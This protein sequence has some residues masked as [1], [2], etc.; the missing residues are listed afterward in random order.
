MHRAASEVTFR[1]V[2]GPRTKESL[3]NTLPDVMTTETRVAAFLLANVGLP[4]C[5]PCMAVELRQ[6]E[7][8]VVNAAAT[9]AGSDRF[10]ITNRMCARC[11][12]QQAVMYLGMK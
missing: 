7:N 1:D 6:S 4:F 12:S 9:I 3:V 5:M 2:D 8:A 10:R 11:F